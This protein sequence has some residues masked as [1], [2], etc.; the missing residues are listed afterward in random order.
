MK[1]SFTFTVLIAFMFL[2]A[3]GD[4]TSAEIPG[5]KDTSI[6]GANEVIQDEDLAKDSFIDVDKEENEIIITIQVNAETN[7]EKA[8]SLS[9]SIV[10]SL[11]SQVAAQDDNDM[12]GPSK[13]Y[14]GELWD[15]YDLQI[16]VGTNKDN[17]IVQ[18]AKVTSA[19]KITW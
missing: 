14:L 5:I 18:G 8:K 9:D 1:K 17:F 3:C 7:E 16:G 10:R 19:D 2:T 15:H 13:D 6:D 4:E 11:S 12:E